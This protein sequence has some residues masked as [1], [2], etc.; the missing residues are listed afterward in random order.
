MW[1]Q[2]FCDFQLLCCCCCCCSNKLVCSL[3]IIQQQMHCA[4]SPTSNPITSDFSHLRHLRHR[5]QLP[6]PSAIYACDLLFRYSQLPCEAH[7]IIVVRKHFRRRHGQTWVE[8]YETIRNLNPNNL[9]KYTILCT[10]RGWGGWRC[11]VLHSKC[12]YS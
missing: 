5:F 3:L 9:S 10:P 2:P 11:A 1:Q 6:A 12:D 4:S 8:P 7:E